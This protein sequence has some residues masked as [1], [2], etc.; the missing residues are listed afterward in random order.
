MSDPLDTPC[1]YCGHRDPDPRYIPVHGLRT[2][3]VPACRDREACR[4]REAAR[5]W[6]LALAC[7]RATGVIRR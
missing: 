6:M 3:G 7:W 2:Q 1:Y 5:R 4:E